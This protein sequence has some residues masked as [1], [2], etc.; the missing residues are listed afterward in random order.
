MYDSRYTGYSSS[1]KVE[2]LVKDFIEKYGNDEQK[3]RY[4]EMCR[5]KWGSDVVSIYGSNQID[6]VMCMEYRNN[7]IRNK[8]Q[9]K[10]QAQQ[11]IY[12]IIAKTQYELEPDWKPNWSNYIERKYYPYF[13]HKNKMIEFYYEELCQSVDLRL[14]MSEKVVVYI[15]KNSLITDEMWLKAFN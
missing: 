10:L 4:K 12:D 6:R 15:I 14:Y 11:L 3:H 1:E 5:P 8:Y 9:E 13:N 2:I 7:N